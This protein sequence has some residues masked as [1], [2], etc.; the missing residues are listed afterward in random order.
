MHCGWWRLRNVWEST[1][2]EHSLLQD[3]RLPQNLD[4]QELRQ[5]LHV[6]QLDFWKVRVRRVAYIIDDL[7][8]LR[9]RLWQSLVRVVGG[10]NYGEL[11]IWQ[12][13]RN[14][15]LSRWSSRYPEIVL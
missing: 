3:D 2:E 9:L 15:A 5:R 1:E 13:L 6:Q 14:M 8:L 4:L 7:L 11:R 10:D 12:L